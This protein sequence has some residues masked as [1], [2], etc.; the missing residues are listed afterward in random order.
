VS[1]QKP[2]APKTSVSAALSEAQSII[3]AA[4]QRAAELT[5]TAEAAYEKA[6]KTGYE[7]G[8]Q[9]GRKDASGQAL[10]L[11]EESSLIGSKLSAE[12]A[13]L[14]MAICATVIGE[15]VKVDPDLVRRIAERALQQSVVGDVITI[16]A[17]PDDKKV[18][19]KSIDSFRRLAGGASVSIEEDETMARGGC[20]VRTEFGEVDASLSM[21]LDSIAAKLGLK[22]P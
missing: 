12:A 22:N 19:T 4:E 18:L 5:A 15:H 11:I 20:I 2:I 21:L 17:H 3:G 13:K 10:R 7:D 9:E 8:F 16:V 6:R 14:S 1:T